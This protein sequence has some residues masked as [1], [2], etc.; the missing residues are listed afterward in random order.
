MTRPL[1]SNCFGGRSD[2]DEAYRKY[3]WVLAYLCQT[4]GLDPSR[5][6]VGHFFLDPLR[7]TDPLTGLAASRR[8]YDALLRDVVT[9]YGVCS[10][11]APVATRNLVATPGQAV[12]AARLCIRK[13]APNRSADVVQ[14]VSPGTELAYEG[15]VTDGETVN[16]NST[17]FCDANGNYFWSGGIR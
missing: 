17:W 11:N 4:F 12:A 15:W 8:T 2:A 3:V 1:A 5:S 10:G 6:V 13:G 7:K 14:V 9:E 16:G